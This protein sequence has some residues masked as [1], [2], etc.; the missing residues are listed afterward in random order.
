MIPFPVFIGWDAREVVA[1]DV[2]RFSLLR[3]A[4]IPLHV[5]ALRR[6]ELIEK[7]LYSRTFTRL[8]NGQ[9]IDDQDGRPFSTEFSF[10]RFLVPHLMDHKGW[11]L[12]CDCDFLFRADVEELMPLLDDSK[13][14]MV[15]KQR[16]IPAESVKMDGQ[17]QISYER[18][19]WSSFILWNCAH[20]AH[21]VFYPYDVSTESGARLHRFCWLSD[22]DI[23]ALP[24]QWNWIEGTTQGEPKAVHFT[25]GGP[26]FPGYDAVA[27][28]HE[29]LNERSLS[30][31]TA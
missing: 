18:K 1:F 23:G 22:G 9:M 10:T 20:P 7:R 25:A 29:W 30:E 17:A 27:F 16:H 26:W 6:D 28:A 3:H 15:C 5:Q 21:R 8:H 12:F 2:C 14:I 24:P 13:A 4:S 11:A 31:S 19:N